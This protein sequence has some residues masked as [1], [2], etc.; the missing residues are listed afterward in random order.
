MVLIGTP[1][2]PLSVYRE[3]PHAPECRHTCRQSACSKIWEYEHVNNPYAPNKCTY[4][5]V[6]LLYTCI[7]TQC[8]HKQGV[9]MCIYI[10]RVI[11]KSVQASTQAGKAIYIYYMYM[12]VLCGITVDWWP[13]STNCK[14]P[15]VAAMNTKNT[16]SQLKMWSIHRLCGTR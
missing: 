15:G 8:Q 13:A 14:D 3:L 9:V 2:S 1:G 6:Q 11:M 16:E 5:T 10:Q 7:F 4:W 12:Y